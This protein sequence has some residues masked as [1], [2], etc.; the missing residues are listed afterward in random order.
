[1]PPTVRVRHPP[2]AVRVPRAA[3]RPPGA[4]AVDRTVWPAAGRAGRSGVTPAERPLPGTYGRFTGS[5]RNSHH[6][7]YQDLPIYVHF[8]P[9]ELAQTL[10]EAGLQRTVSSR[11]RQVSV[12]GS[13]LDEQRP[14]ATC[15]DRGPYPA[16]R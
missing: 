14:E 10:C 16:S 2:A 13:R 11:V 1:W 5:P 4:A 9:V 8:L 15:P 3:D 7:L 6:V 12:N